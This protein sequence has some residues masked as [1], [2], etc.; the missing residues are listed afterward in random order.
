MPNLIHFLQTMLNL[1]D[2]LA[3]LVLLLALK[4]SVYHIIRLPYSWWPKCVKFDALVLVGPLLD[5][6]QSSGPD[7]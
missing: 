5:L 7:N 4:F 1:Q 2:P 6:M 3:V